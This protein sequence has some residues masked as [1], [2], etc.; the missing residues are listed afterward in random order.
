VNLLWKVVK[1][2]LVLM[3]AV[4]LAIIVLAT[5]LGIF[6]ALLGLAFLALRLAVIGLVAYGAFRL[7]GKLVG[8]RKTVRPPPAQLSEPA[9]DP[10]YDEAMRELDRD[11]GHVR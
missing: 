4:P 7:V 2:A 3:F 1:V 11:I 9:R 10:Y 5:A 8:G 6:G